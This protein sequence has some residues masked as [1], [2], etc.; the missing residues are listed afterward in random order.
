VQVGTLGAGFS[1]EFDRTLMNVRGRLEFRGKYSIGA[2]CRFDIGP[3]AKATFGKGYTNSGTTFII[4]NE[5]EV[6]DDCCVSWGCQFLDDDFHE[7][8]Y[9]GKVQR[10]SAIRLGNHVL[11]GSRANILKG[12]TIADHCV[13]ASGAVVTKSFDTPHCLIAGNPAGVI[14]EQVSWS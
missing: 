4:S 8:H 1:H 7:V 10:S 12:V 3:D 11:V 2:G 6:G 5:L 13:I 9:A 14:R